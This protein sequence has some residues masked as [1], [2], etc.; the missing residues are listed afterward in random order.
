MPDHKFRQTDSGQSSGWE[1]QQTGRGRPVIP[2]NDFAVRVLNIGA[3]LIN[4]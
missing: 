2:A 1:W 3:G 4:Q